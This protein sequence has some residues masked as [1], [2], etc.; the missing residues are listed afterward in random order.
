MKVLR[1]G[2]QGHQEANGWISVGSDGQDVSN[3][4]TDGAGFLSDASFPMVVHD[5]IRN[6]Q[7]TDDWFSSP[8]NGEKRG[9]EE[10]WKFGDTVMENK[11]VSTL[12]QKVVFLLFL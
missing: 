1:I 5:R 11:V 3:G 8:E 2:S 4:G 12:G 9:E 7:N 6:A 10:F